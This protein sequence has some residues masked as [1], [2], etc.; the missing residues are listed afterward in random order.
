MMAVGKN[1]CIVWNS[2]RIHCPCVQGMKYLQFVKAET[3]GLK[4]KALLFNRQ[5]MNEWDLEFQRI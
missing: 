5:G 4:Q 1:Q 2:S 3:V